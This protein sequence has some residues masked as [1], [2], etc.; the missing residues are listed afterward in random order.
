MNT[1]TKVN[2]ELADFHCPETNDRVYRELRAQ[3]LNIELGFTLTRD[4]YDR[5][6]DDIIPS[7]LPADLKI[8]C[9]RSG[10]NYETA[11][12]AGEDCK[13]ILELQ[14][15]ISAAVMYE[16][17]IERLK[18]EFI[19]NYLATCLNDLQ[20]AD[21]DPGV[22]EIFTTESTIKEY[23]Y[24]LYYY[25]QAGNLVKTIPPNGVH[26]IT[27][28]N[29]LDQVK[30]FRAGE[31]GVAAY[32]PSHTYETQYRYNSLNEIVRQDAPDTYT[33]TPND[34]EGSEM[35]YDRVGRLVVSQDG[36]QRKFIPMRYSYTIYDE[37]GRITE[38][39]E[40]ASTEPMTVEKA[41][42]EA[43]LEAWIN[44]LSKGT[45]YFITKTFYDRPFDDNG[46][47]I[48]DLSSVL[49]EGQTNLRPRV[50]SVTY[51]ERLSDDN[52]PDFKNYDYATHYSYD[53]SGN[54][55]T[56]I[57]E[58]VELHPYN[59]GFKRIDYDY[60][61]ISGNVNAVYYQRGKADQFTHRYYY[62]ENNRLTEVKSSLI[63]TI[64]EDSPFWET[65]ATYEYYLHGPLSRME[66]GN[67]RVQGS[68]Y[69]YTLQSWIKGVNSSHLDPSKDIGGDGNS[70][71]AAAKDAMGYT[72]NYYQDDYK[73]IGGATN[74]EE[75]TAGTSI[76]PSLYNGNIRMMNVHIARL[77]DAMTYVYNYDQLHR[78]KE[79][80]SDVREYNNGTLTGLFSNRYSSQY[81][82][83]GNGN[84]C[85]LKRYGKNGISD[86]MDNLTYEYKE[87]DDPNEPLYT[88]LLTHVTD[89]A[90]D[91]TDIKDVTTQAAGNYQY[92]PAG[93]LVED[94]QA[95]VSITW[96]AYG[97]VDRI[98]FG[99]TNLQD[100]TRFGYDTAQNR[101]K[102][103][104]SASS[105]TI[106]NTTYYI[107]DAQGN[108]M[109]TYHLKEETELNTTNTTS[110]YTWEEQHLYGS[111]RLGMV[112]T[113]VLLFEDN[114]IVETSA[115]EPFDMPENME[116][117][118]FK[119]AAQ[120]YSGWKRY[121]CSN[122]LGNVLAVVSDRKKGFNTDGDLA[123]L[124]DHFEPIVLSA[125][126]YYPFG[127]EMPGRR[128]PNTDAKDYR[129]GFNGKEADT[130]SEWGSLTHYD[131]GFR[132]YNPG[133]GKFL[134]V[135]PLTK[136]YPMLTPYQFASNMPIWAIDL[137]GL[138]HY[139]YYHELNKQG[140]LF[141]T[142]TAEDCAAPFKETYI[143][144]HKNEEFHF[145]DQEKLERFSRIR[146]SGEGV[147][148][149]SKELSKLEEEV[150]MGN[151]YPGTSI[152]LEGKVKLND[153]FEGKVQATLGF[154]DDVKFVGK[155]N[156]A[157]SVS[158]P[159]I[160]TDLIGVEGSV[161]LLSGNTDLKFVA[162]IDADNLIK[163]DLSPGFKGTVKI[164][165]NDD[166]ETIVEFQ[167]SSQVK[168]KR[169]RGGIENIYLYNHG[170]G[171][172]GKT[173]NLFIEVKFSNNT[174]IKLKV[175]SKAFLDT[176]DDVF[177]GD[178][179][180][181]AL[182]AI[183]ENRNNFLE[184]R[185][186]SNSNNENQ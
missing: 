64:T 138:E 161:S 118:Y 110:T 90:G 14:A 181:R 26:P 5:F 147:K 111:S 116:M 103:Q 109:A 137:D 186:N 177:S 126:D 174:S 169:F 133:I 148:F 171:G 42:D 85:N 150:N 10:F 63:E 134:S 142:C 95:D 7:S 16:S 25:D 98:D 2:E 176:A 167:S 91:Y 50:V 69:A 80:K 1:A 164:Y 54:V 78:I 115:R 119:E 3:H 52:D 107:R 99:A 100:Y 73:A 86:E 117:P 46:D 131:Y 124:A 136:I 168:L 185:N 11:P 125:Q 104:S 15:K 102:K 56:L 127:M 48:V 82:Y 155:V 128:T 66:V 79:M 113:K 37:Q 173:Q 120:L 156:S 71:Y 47:P 184:N 23:H 140:E 143:L 13:A 83:D 57:Q 43:D 87:N 88:N 68:D 28:Q 76:T 141:Y 70:P 51:N 22:G 30:N 139:F 20:I 32:Y 159:G 132:I 34:K 170:T 62:D 108:I 112:A 35:W 180:I 172:K 96:N 149:G 58:I 4:D 72:L 114:G 153:S 59:Q 92:D 55:K 17:E 94:A 135:D 31:A 6:I 41:R 93:N 12:D 175:D 53:A 152:V 65:E 29:R 36:R 157:A 101:V 154:K 106:I 60:D 178:T 183:E 84:L 144:L 162:D 24:T 130:K 18:Q 19:D 21:Q 146:V 27:E 33:D 105:E 97:K 40:K 165:Q 77:E 158:K 74:F 67:Q 179:Y 129:F 81:T 166:N 163:G 151:L 9:P 89:A 160:V 123:N 61:Y 145:D 8:L 38:V 182:K 39:G 44:D 121:E 45:K 49:P 75:Y 122:H